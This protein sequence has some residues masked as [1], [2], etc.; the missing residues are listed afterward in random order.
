[1][2]S[3]IVL[4]TPSSA[5]KPQLELDH[6]ADGLQSKGVAVLRC[7]EDLVLKEPDKVTE[8]ISNNNLQSVLIISRPSET[9]VTENLQQT[10]QRAG[11][12]RL[13][14]GYLDVKLLWEEPRETIAST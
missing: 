7:N 3:G 13:A 2:K 14:V 6:L 11:L 4:C 1:M 5:S 8:F 9:T 10:T 12:G